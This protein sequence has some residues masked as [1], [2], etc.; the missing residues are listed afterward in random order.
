MPKKRI[1]LRQTLTQGRL[2]L[3]FHPISLSVFLL[4]LAGCGFQQPGTS[5]TSL[6]VS[7]CQTNMQQQ[8][9]QPIGLYSIHMFSE[10]AGWGLSIGT[11]KDQNGTVS[12]TGETCILHTTDGGSHWKV[13]KTW[14]LSTATII[15]PFFPFFFSETTAWV[16]V[17]NHLSSTNDA[18]TTWLT[19]D[20]PLASGESAL[21]RNLTFV[22]GN[23]GWLMT[24]INPSSTP[25]KSAPTSALF[26]TSDGGHHWKQLLR[27]S[28]NSSS[29]PQINAG[30]KIYFLTATTGWMTGLSILPGTASQREWLFMTGDGGRTWQPQTLPLPIG[31]KSLSGLSLG[32]P[33]FYS[34]RDG[35]LPASINQSSD[36]TPNGFLGFVTH[37]GGLSWQS[38][39]FVAEDYNEVYQKTLKPGEVNDLVYRLTPTPQFTDMQFG[40]V[41]DPYLEMFITSDGGQHW[42]RLELRSLP[43]G[44]EQIQFISSSVGWGMIQSDDG[45]SS[46][47]YRTTDG[48]KTWTQVIP[49]IV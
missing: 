46:R 49:T 14:E 12:L 9:G 7:A 8:V 43:K 31:V 5:A 6:H 20:L 13:V 48:G 29:T 32:Q 19:S 24:E 30:S 10:T 47:L 34:S 18:G 37:D 42:Q 40:W 2:N 44:V 4:V 39:P 11:V 36:G 25:P 28:G 45:R 27:V 1:V 17:E 21:I 35:I 3:L 15:T 26:H 16:A 22:D 41:G 23:A 38:Q 33:R